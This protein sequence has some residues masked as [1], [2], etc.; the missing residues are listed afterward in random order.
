[1][2]INSLYLKQIKFVEQQGWLYMSNRITENALFL[3][4]LYV[5]SQKGKANTSEVK[6]ILI[7]VFNPTGED[8]E[9]LAGRNDTKFSQK[10]RNLM[11]SHYETNGMSKNTK[12]DNDGFFTLTPLGEK[13][14]ADNKEYLAH[15]FAGGFQYE[16]LKEFATKI[17]ENQT[18]EHKLYLYDEND[19]VFEGKAEVRTTIV[20][21][22]SKKLRE[23]AIQRYTLDGKIKCA[24]CGFDFG[25][26]YGKQGEGY[27]QIH[28]ES[29][30]Y[31]Y[32]NEGLTSYIEEAI[33]NTKPLCANCHC[34][35]HRKKSNLLTVQELKQII[36][37]PL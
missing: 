37:K 27:I 32:S 23:A 7:S 20:K 19:L 12:K 24:A 31:Q 28:H 16:G 18:Q 36:R 9:I 3:P 13:T 6:N 26:F 10:V 8:N 30:I 2:F 35:I 11:G 22:R 15:I 25:E 1:M 5:I 21:E 4:A 34:M 29:P 33:K 17:Y 14:V